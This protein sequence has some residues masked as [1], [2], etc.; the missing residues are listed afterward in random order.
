MSGLGLSGLVSGFDTDALIEKILK[1]ENKRVTNEQIKKAQLEAKQDAWKQV[2]SSL[3]T[4]RSKLDAVRLASTFS[5]RSATLTDGAVASVT[6]AAGASSTTHTLEV[7]T[8][9]SYSV[10]ASGNLAKA[11]D[12]ATGLA[13]GTKSTITVTVNGKSTAVELTDTD[14]LMSI[15]DKINGTKDIGVKAEVV[16]VP[17]GAET[18]YR[19]V[20]S[21]NTQGKNGAIA[22]DGDAALLTTLGFKDGAG[23]LNELSKGQD[24]VFKLN[25]VDYTSATNTISDILPGMT[26]TLKKAGTTSITIDQDK[27]ATVKAV[28]EWVNALNATYDLLKDATKYDPKTNKKGLL[29]GDSLIRT[30]QSSLRSVIS[31]SVTGLPDNLNRLSQ[32]GISTGIFGTADYG[33]VVLDK[34]KLKDALANDELGVAKLF[35]AVPNNVALGSAGA[36][37]DPETDQTAGDPAKMA[38]NVINGDTSSERFGSSGGGWESP[39]VPSASQPQKLVI[40]LKASRTIEQIRLYQPDNDTYK[41]SATGLKDFKVEYLDGNG[42]WQT[43]ETVTNHSGSYRTIQFEPKLASKIRIT[44][45]GTYGDAPARLTEVEVHAL[46]DGPANAMHRFVNTTLFQAVTGALDTHDEAIKL[47]VDQA[48]KQI[49][50]LSEALIKREA[51]LR[52]QFSRME[53][54]LARLQ[55]QGSYVAMMGQMLSNGSS[56]KK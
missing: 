27:E 49:D 52:D 34:A 26:L 37:I 14:T 35:G 54:T 31:R 17:V 46:N 16:K 6:T 15:R 4:L 8:L 53:Q 42:T 19:L 36:V 20:L 47:Q 41:A 56:G 22:L 10:V 38:A 23:T 1:Y 13:A 55:G 21:S 40:D 39:L 2:R 33:K 32:V 44:V 45:T 5:A 12:P 25:G 29:N 24:A 28:E 11:T 18:K 50:K 51:Q 9:A 43:L 48:S 7:T 3:S 30:I